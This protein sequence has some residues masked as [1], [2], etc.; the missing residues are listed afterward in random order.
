MTILASEAPER[1][2]PSCSART[3]YVELVWFERRIER[4]I[5]FGRWADE[6]ILDRRTRFVGFAAGEVFAFVRWAAN[7]QGRTAVSRLDIVRATGRGEAVTTLPGVLPGGEL[8]LH[9][10]G[11]PVVERALQLVDAVEALGVDAADAA[12]DYWRHVHNRL[13]VSEPA[14]PYSRERHAAW[15]MRRELDA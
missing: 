8:L 6:R 10:S 3:T 9:L 15:L 12:P 11:W 1:P 13:S 5:R 4:W 7:A 14:R 2:L